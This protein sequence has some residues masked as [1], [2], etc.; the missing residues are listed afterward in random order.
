[1]GF[2]WCSIIGKLYGKQAPSELNTPH[3]ITQ[4]SER[5]SVLKKSNGELHQQAVDF[6]THLAVCNTV[7]PAT[8]AANQLIYQVRHYFHLFPMLK[9]AVSLAQS[10][11]ASLQ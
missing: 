3:T 5:L 7:V 2:G 1:M 6:L 8:T 9:A 11:L 4:N 10:I